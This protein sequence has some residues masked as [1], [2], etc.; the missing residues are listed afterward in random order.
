M[1]EMVKTF[2]TFGSSVQDLGKASSRGPPNTSDSCKAA[3]ALVL[4]EG[5]Q[6]GSE[7]LEDG[8]S[9]DSSSD[10]GEPKGEKELCGKKFLFPSHETKTL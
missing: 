2:Q 5:E 4:A 6:R 9:G 1:V 7:D 3:P 10:K 8:S